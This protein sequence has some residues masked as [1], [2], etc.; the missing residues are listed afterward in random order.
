MTS[1]YR[2][3]IVLFS[4][5]ALLWLS[6]YFS[7]L[8]KPVLEGP[9]QQAVLAHLRGLHDGQKVPDLPALPPGFLSLKMAFSLYLFRGDGKLLA[10]VHLKNPAEKKMPEVVAELKR[11]AIFAEEIGKSPLLKS[12]QKL[13]RNKN[14]LAGQKKIFVRLSPTAQQSI[15]FGEGSKSGFISHSLP[16][17]Q[18]N[19]ALIFQKSNTRELAPEYDPE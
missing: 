18:N 13:S 3:F 12:L 11:K 5:V 19:R 6:C 7:V 15:V 16:V 14:P 9:E 10:Q 1:L 8:P 17:L 2:F 4:F